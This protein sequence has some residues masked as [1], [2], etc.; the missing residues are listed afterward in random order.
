VIL[1]PLVVITV[2]FT[3]LPKD[4]PVEVVDPQPVLAKARQESPYPVVAPAN[5]PKD[6]R[7]TR[8][9]WIRTGEPYLNGQPSVRN[10]W[11]LGYLDP[12]DRYVAV[13]Q[14]D[15]EVDDLI[16]AETRDGVADGQS[17]VAGEVWQ[18]RVSPDERTRALV[19]RGADVTTIVEGD[20]GYPQLEAFAS[21]LASS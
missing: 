14:G 10:L 12:D 21:T 13:V 7:P 17:T 9:A 19:R 4:H 18:R 6:W 20:I 3:K 8:V 1:I 2:L 16:A 11:R 15:A 5:L